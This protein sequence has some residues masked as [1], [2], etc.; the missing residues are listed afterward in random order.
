MFYEQ[1]IKEIVEN[2]IVYKKL[3]DNEQKP[4]LNYRQSSNMYSICFYISRSQNYIEVFVDLE[5]YIIEFETSLALPEELLNKL[6]A[7]LECL[8]NKKPLILQLRDIYKN[9]L[10]KIT[11]LKDYHLGKILNT[12]GE[13]L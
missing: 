8:K 2:F 5:N 1:D 12:V 6:K 10:V 4:E 13:F 11:I 3:S 7:D 9:S